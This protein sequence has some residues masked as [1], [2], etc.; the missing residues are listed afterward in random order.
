MYAVTLGE[1]RMRNLVGPR[2]LK[3]LTPPR[4]ELG[5]RATK[6]VGFGSGFRDAGWIGRLVRYADQYLRL[7]GVQVAAL[8]HV[9]VLGD[10]D[11]GAENIAVRILD[12]LGVA[13]P[14]EAEI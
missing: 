10:I 8:D 6:Q 2:R 1:L 12:R 11:G 7:R 9:A 5:E 13:D 4:R 3:N 14:L